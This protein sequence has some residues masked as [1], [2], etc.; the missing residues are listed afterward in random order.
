VQAGGVTTARSVD[1]AP[2]SVA[3]WWIGA[4]AGLVS[5]GSGLASAELLAG[6]SASLRS[7]LVSVGDRVVDLAPRWLKTWAI[8][9]F[10]TTDKAVLLTGVA[11]VL[12]VVASLLGVLAVRRSRRVALLG[13]AVVGLLG[14]ATA[15]GRGRAGWS[16]PVP[17][18]V[19]SAVAGVVLWYLAGLARAGWAADLESA[20]QR[21]VGADRAV[22]M[23]ALQAGSRR[24]FLGAAG[25]FAVGAVALGAAGRWLQQQA[26]VTAERL[27]IAL[28]RPVRPLPPVPA[29]V[30]VAVPGVTPFITPTKDFF[31]I[32]TALAVPNVS[33][34]GWTLRVTGDVEREL[35]LTYDELLARPMVEAD[36][37][38]ACVSNE[39][40][41]D[42]IGTARWLGCRL[43]DLL[44]EAGVLSRAD[45]VVGVSV[46]GFTAGFPTALLDDRDALVAVGMNGEPLPARHGFPAR[47]VVPG[48]YGYVSA[49]KWLTEIR[50]TRFDEFEGYWIP[51]GWSREGP[52]KTQSRIDVPRPGARLLAGEPTAIAGVAWAPT[53]GIT[54]VEVQV[55][56]GPWQTATLG[57]DYA[58]TTWRQWSVLWTP[59]PGEH[60]I[61]VRTTDGSG[62]T[63]TSQI[64]D[65]APDGATGWHAVAVTAV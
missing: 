20:S 9:T 48:V 24:R 26:S 46:D 40:G 1:E 42:L 23:A 55:D 32:D 53:R 34:D 14:A 37:T 35:T 58:A 6:L 22:S 43:A 21:E 49:T 62:A 50:L 18:L 29:G 47:L 27:R 28:P 45:Q 59:Q 65:V 41:G 13:A 61:R 54:R 15:L 56:D 12:I 16:A 4:A 8:D 2:R 57:Q 11:L 44:D 38:I 17:T 3:P 33:T 52:I 31:R 30:S 51:R 64:S 25:G 7:P 19:G 60:T 10:G 36:L 5:L 39:V 63:Q